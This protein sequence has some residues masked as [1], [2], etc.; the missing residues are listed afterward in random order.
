MTL[1]GLDIA[2]YLEN[3]V[4]GIVLTLSLVVL[5][6]A[7]PT[8]IE[9]TP[10]SSLF[11]AF[12]V[13]LVAGFL[14]VS[15]LL[16]LLSAMISRFVVDSISGVAIRPV[17]L[18][19]L[20]HTSYQQL[21]KIL[22]TLPDERPHWRSAWNQAYRAALRYVT[23]NGPERA[24]AEVWRRREQ[25]RLVR[26]LFFPL[27]LGTMAVLYWLHADSWMS[28]AAVVSGVALLSICLYSY[29]EYTIFAEAV[30]HLPTKP[31]RRSDPTE[32][33]L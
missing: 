26:N 20:S 2:I 24:R 29:A 7:V 25:G 33:A 22:E 1:E 9:S 28:N 14:S 12:P 16:G 27:V 3:L 13:I 4:P 18:H 31:V 5:L 8:E 23:L 11:N 15:Y 30:L 32:P 6:P 19:W 17:L 21:Q 10:A